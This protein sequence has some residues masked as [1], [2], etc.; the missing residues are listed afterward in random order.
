MADRAGLDE[1]SVALQDLEHV[2]GTVLQIG[3]G[4]QL[5]SPPS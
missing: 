3:G 5:G 4:L 2:P 1:L